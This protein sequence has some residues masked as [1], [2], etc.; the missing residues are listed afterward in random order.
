MGDA[1]PLPGDPIVKEGE[2]I[3]Y[4]TSASPG[5][6]VGGCAALGYIEPSADPDTS[7]F[8]VEVLGEARVSRRLDAWGYDPDHS[9]CRGPV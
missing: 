8:G 9:R 7:G 5:D 2:V 6:R 4:V 3:G 1:E